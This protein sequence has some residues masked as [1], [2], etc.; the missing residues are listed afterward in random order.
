MN[1]KSRPAAAFLEVCREVR[2]PWLFAAR[3]ALGCLVALFFAFRFELENP[4]SAALTVVIISLPQSG[5]VIEKAFYRL[6][7]TLVGGAA[8]LLL[9]AIFVQQREFFLVGVACWIGLC[10]GLSIKLRNFRAYAFVLSGYTACLVGLPAFMQ[11]D[12]AFHIAVDRVSAVCLG[13]L[14]GT[15]LNATVLPR[16]AAEQLVR[17]VR[18]RLPD[19]IDYARAVLGTPAPRREIRRHQDRL[20]HDVVALES[21]R[22]ASYFENA[23]SRIRSTRL[24][25]LNSDFMASNT[26]L[27][28][29]YRLREDLQAR[30]EQRMI[31][32][33]EPLTEQLLTQ[34][35][36]AQGAIPATAAEAAA[37]AERFGHW[38][39]NWE[40]HAETVRE[41]FVAREAVESRELNANLQLLHW[42]ALDLSHYLHDY[43]G[44]ADPRELSGPAA[45]RPASR[46]DGLVVLV[47]FL[48][49]ALAIIVGGTFWILSGWAHGFF[50]FIAV[51]VFP[52]LFAAAPNP[53]VPIKGTVKGFLAGAVAAVPLYLFVL[54][55][56]DGYWELAAVQLP[57]LLLF[58]YWVAQPATSGRGFGALLIFLSSLAFTNPITPDVAEFL[59]RIV[60][61]FIGF[62]FVALAYTAFP[63]PGPD[64][65]TGRLQRALARQLRVAAGCPVDRVR[66]EFET[67]VTD[68]VTQ[69]VLRFSAD[70]EGRQQQLDAGLTVLESGYALIRL[71]EL[72]VVGHEFLQ[73]ICGAFEKP[74]RLDLAMARIEGI[75]RN[76]PPDPSPKAGAA[77]RLLRLGLKEW[78]QL[79]TPPEPELPLEEPAHAT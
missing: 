66:H 61:T 13:L 18:Q 26:A 59:N 53:L 55:A 10:T 6:C 4:S 2:E 30:G 27:H 64:W 48:R 31:V 56:I 38:V 75:I 50:A 69:L 49:S 45:R 65:V 32:A 9:V 70:N 16:S 11:P 58:G 40:Q 15:L 71:R 23:D 52:A 1:R 62:G 12:N 41:R 25:R 47:A 8:S 29:I 5:Y 3:T 36:T 20:L 7:G 63:L 68:L 22:G 39:Q 37:V 35:E 24:Q 72:E 60:A 79:S 34:L 51:S 78:R 14:C 76:P 77:L 67:G 21:I 54:P 74:Q 46:S 43:V 19:F 17:I 28:A 57:A 42:F 33:I 73:L 44:L